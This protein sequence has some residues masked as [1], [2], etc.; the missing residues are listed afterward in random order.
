MTKKKEKKR[1][2][3]RSSYEESVKGK[4]DDVSGERQHHEVDL[5]ILDGHEEP[6]EDALALGVDVGLAHVLE[7]A[8]LRHLELLLGE[9]ARVVR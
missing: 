4:T 7:H 1:K 6:V 8:Q 9:A 5:D 2:E 3:K